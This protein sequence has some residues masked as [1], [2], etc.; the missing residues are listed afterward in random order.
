MIENL[1]I[2]T[3]EGILLFSKN[4]VKLSKPDDIIAGFFT[5]VDIFI[6]EITKE[7][8]KN[9]SMRDHKFNYIIGDDL[10]IVISTN[11]HDNDILIQNLLREVKIIFLEKYSE[12]L[13]FFSG[14]IIPFINFDE[15]LGVLIKD[16]DVSIKCQIC[17][18]IVVGEFRYKNID[19][20]KIYFCCTSCEIAFSYDK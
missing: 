8:I 9:I 18:K 1:W 6:R 13:K 5:A 15:D 10:I 19:N 17:K 12:E 7:E 14:D 4:F 16:L 11:E 2:L 20:H 3:K